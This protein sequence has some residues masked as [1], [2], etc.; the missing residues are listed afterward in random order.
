MC[1]GGSSHL[2]FPSC[3]SPQ[4]GEIGELS[5]FGASHK[6]FFGGNVH[7]FMARVSSGTFASVTQSPLRQS[8]L[9]WSWHKRGGAWQAE[10]RTMAVSLP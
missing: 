4:M 8:L 2:S 6:V 10:A 1:A 3:V 9:G 5:D 7:I